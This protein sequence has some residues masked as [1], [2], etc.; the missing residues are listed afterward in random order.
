VEEVEDV[1]LSSDA[2]MS[3]SDTGFE[4]HEDASSVVLPSSELGVRE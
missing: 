4:I 1:E 3:S 2:M